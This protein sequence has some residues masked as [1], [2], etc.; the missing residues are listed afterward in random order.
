MYTYRK[1]D[2]T[3]LLL[4]ILPVLAEKITKFDLTAVSINRECVKVLTDALNSPHS[5][6]L[7][8]SLSYCT[9][10]CIDYF[11]LTL[12]IATSRLTKFTSLNNGIDPMSAMG[13]ARVLKQSKTLKEVSLLDVHISKTIANILVKAMN[14]SAVHKLHV[15]RVRKADFLQ[16]H[17][18]GGR[19]CLCV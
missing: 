14:D 8:L 18:R 19:Y 13:L 12:F 16:K 5:C 1:I 2:I 4:G 6:L 11:I 3:P 10:S 9:I 15:Q 7:E 17:Y